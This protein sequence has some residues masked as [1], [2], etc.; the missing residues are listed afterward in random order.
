MNPFNWHFHSGTLGLICTFQTVIVD[1]HQISNVGLIKVLREGSA[2]RAPLLWGTRLSSSPHAVAQLQ[3]RSIWRVLLASTAPGTHTWYTDINA[4]TILT[5]IQIKTKLNHCLSTWFKENVVWYLCV[6]K[7][8][9]QRWVV[10]FYQP[11]LSATAL[12]S[13]DFWVTEKGLV[14][15]YS[16]PPG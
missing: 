10:I 11:S 15:I 7:N 6:M 9:G 12:V 3:L 8:S 5:Y 2:V 14:G 4:S 16:Q 1:M 13:T